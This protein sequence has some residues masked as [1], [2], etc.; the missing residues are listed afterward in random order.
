MSLSTAKRGTITLYAP[1]SKSEQ[2]FMYSG[3][4]PGMTFEA[5]DECVRALVGTRQVWRKVRKGFV[6]R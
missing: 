5:F 4:T 6:E 2:E 3:K 1:P